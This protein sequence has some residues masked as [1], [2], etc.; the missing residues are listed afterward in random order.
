MENLH[1]GNCYD[2]VVLLFILA[3]ETFL[4]IL[5]FS[6]QNFTKF[7]YYSVQSD[8]ITYLTHQLRYICF[9]IL[10]ELSLNIIATVP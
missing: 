9:A 7:L 4:E 5:K 10:K 8:V 1:A 2:N 6:L 3:D